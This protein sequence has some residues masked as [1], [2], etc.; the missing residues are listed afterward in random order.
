MLDLKKNQ[1]KMRI[2]LYEL[3]LKSNFRCLK[4]CNKILKTRKYNQ[5]T[6]KNK[7]PLFT[8]YF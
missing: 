1:Y 2:R 8:A 7:Y 3:T 5:F 6:H 4:V